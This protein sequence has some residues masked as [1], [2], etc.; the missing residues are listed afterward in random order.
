VQNISHVSQYK[1]KQ[2]K[3]D[4]LQQAIFTQEALYHQHTSHMFRTAYTLA[5]LNRPLS[6]LSGQ[7][8]ME[9][10]KCIDAGNI[11]PYRK[12]KNRGSSVS[13]VCGCGLDYRTIEVRFPAETK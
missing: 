5:E 13:I 8:D 11:L 2:T 6:D 1:Q 7:L 9:T 3:E 12:K 10:V 4:I